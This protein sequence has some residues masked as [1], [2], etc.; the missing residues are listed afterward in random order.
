MAGLPAL[1]RRSHGKCSAGRGGTAPGRCLEAASSR[2]PHEQGRGC[3]LIN[4]PSQSPPHLPHTLRCSGDRARREM[5]AALCRPPWVRTRSGLL[6]PSRAQPPSLGQGARCRAP[7]RGHHRAALHREEGGGKK[8]VAPPTGL[9]S[10]WVIPLGVSEA[11][12]YLFFQLAPAEAIPP[13]PRRGRLRA[14]WGK[15]QILREARETTDGP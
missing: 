10:C 6:L 8:E 4:P 1:P 5:S 9:A 3:P 15:G 2:G 7:H 12:G 14:S 11:R 13:S